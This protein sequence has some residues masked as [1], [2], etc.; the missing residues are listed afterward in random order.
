MSEPACSDLPRLDLVRFVPTSQDSRTPI[1]PLALRQ[2]P[3]LREQRPAPDSTRLCEGT[4]A[5][6]GCDAPVAIGGGPLPVQQNLACPYCRH[7]ASATD[8]LSLATP[9]RP[10]RVVVRV[11]LQS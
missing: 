2:P 8:F 10:N 9:T 6:P 11:A 3:A 5:C 1:T 4:L 7:R